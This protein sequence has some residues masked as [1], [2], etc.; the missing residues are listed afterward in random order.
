[1]DSHNDSKP[2]FVAGGTGYIG[3]RLIPKL[4]EAG[5]RVRVL[6]RAPEK[7]ADRLWAEH[8]NL[9]IIKGNV[10]DL[11]SLTTAVAP[12]RAAF[13]LV[14]SMLPDVKDFAA[15]DRTAARN[16]ASA[17]SQAGLE[18]IIYLGGL[19]E[20]DHKLSHHLK[21]RTE[22]GDCLREG[23]VPVTILRAAMIIGSGSASF[24]ILRYLVD[25]LPIIISPRW[26]STPCQPIGVRN[27]LYYL[28]G[29]LEKPEMFGQTFDIG[30][31]DVTN[32]R[33]LME[34][35]A[36]EAGLPKRWI[37]PIPILTPRLS[38]YWIHLVT[39]VPASIARPLAEGLRNPV[40]C[41]ENRITE[42]LPQELFDSRKAIRLAL[43]RIHQQQVETTW[44][45]SGT[46]Q[47]AEWSTPGDPGWAGGSA[48]E[49][50]RE[51]TLDATPAEIWPAV[52]S[53]GGDV[54]YYYANWLWTIR[55]L[56]D[57]LSG[58]VGL[59]RGR[60]SSAELHQGDVID[61]WRVLALKRHQ[62]LLLVAEMKLPGKATLS[63][64]LTPLENGGTVLRQTARFLP[65]GL[66]GLIYWYMV[67]PFHFFV[68][69]GML[70]GIAE[71]TKKPIRSGPRRIKRSNNS[72]GS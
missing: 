23:T 63:F 20:S 25:R 35:Y 54:G 50:T 27:V 53:I 52:S 30:K 65:R 66:V 5:Y 3:G 24:E 12:C 34:T 13:Y 38:S 9:E 31:P 33:E 49:D 61:F 8:P 32:Y 47:P 6:A 22:V 55:G 15:T 28:V 67:T 72:D 7:L 45:D 10:L 39:P 59:C 42:L 40:V 48:F 14:H 11:D 16:M 18:Q 26:V 64:K 69:N 29:C 21:S 51:L 2:I 17:A 37:I 60:R 44:T 70:R 71:A 57:R 58:G 68:F 19:G 56:I 4:L 62:Q 41:T 46:L 36:E 1:M 43:D